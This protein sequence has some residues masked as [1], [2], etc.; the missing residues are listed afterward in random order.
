MG[1][2]MFGGRLVQNFVLLGFDEG[3]EELAWFALAL[4]MINPFRAGIGMVPQMVT[5]WGKNS[6]AR[7]QNLVFV[8]LLCTVLTAPVLLMAWTPIGPSTVSTLFSLPD[9]ATA[10]I[11][12]YFRF[13]S[14]VTLLLGWRNVATGLLIRRERTGWVT[15]LKALDVISVVLVLA[16]GIALKGRPSLVVGA[17]ALVPAVV[18]LLLSILLVSRTHAHDEIPGDP[19]HLK[20]LLRYFLPLAGTTFMFS[21]S[22]PIIFRFVRALNPTDSPDGVDTT[23][24]IAALSLAFTVNMMFQI[25]VNQVRH[26]MA[27]YGEAD[28]HGVRRFIFRLA[29]IVTGVMAVVL[30]TPLARL[31]LV[32]CQGA[33]GPTLQMALDCLWVLILVPCVI[34]WR[35]YYHG[36]ALVHRRTTSMAIGGLARNASIIVIGGIFLMTGLLT[37]WTAAG[38][39]LAAFTAEAVVV[40][41]NTRTWRAEHGL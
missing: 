33:E 9:R 5:V 25:T 32:H 18:G 4:S 35:N 36:L 37:H 26:L 15:I 40:M 24:I 12:L 3:V 30:V 41:L 7:R 23:M 6:Q 34:A 10:T 21:L 39:L 28:P 20:P 31:F 14:P 17:S 13:L 22:R 38:L 29:L 2:A 16:A 19:V 11:I 8:T 1:I 27:R